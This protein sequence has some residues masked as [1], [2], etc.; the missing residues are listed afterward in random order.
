M[1]LLHNLNPGNWE[2]VKK[3]G[4]LSFLDKMVK[5]GKIRHKG[6][7]IHNTIEAFKEIVDIFDWEIAQI[8]LNILS[9]PQEDGGASGTASLVL[10]CGNAGRV[11]LKGRLVGHVPRAVS[12][13]EGGN[14]LR[15]NVCYRRALPGRDQRYLIAEIAKKSV[16]TGVRCRQKIRTFSHKRTSLASIACFLQHNAGFPS[17]EA[18][19]MPL[20]QMDKGL[21]QMDKGLNQMDKGLN[22]MDKGLSQMDKELNQMDK[23]LSQM[24]KRLNQMDKGLNQMGKRL[25]PRGT[26]AAQKSP[27]L[28]PC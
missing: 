16:E 18:I 5:K 15:R 26:D 28:C 7:L 27:R 9:E 14:F 6:F 1:Y 11:R 25:A 12:R 10:S 19:L 21:S 4:G 22:Q 23:R 24:D 17:S 13:A 2:V 8:Q 20:N 3:Y